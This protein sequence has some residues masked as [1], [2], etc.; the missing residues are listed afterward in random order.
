M[1]TLF[2]LVL[3]RRLQIESL[4]ES[5]VVEGF[6]VADAGDVVTIRVHTDGQL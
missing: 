4:D 3:D 5:R 1:L 6:G 2:K